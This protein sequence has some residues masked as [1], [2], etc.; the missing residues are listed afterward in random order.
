MFVKG[1]SVQKNVKGDWTN[2]LLT[3][4]ADSIFL[5][6]VEQQTTLAVRHR[7]M[8]SRDVTCF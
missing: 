5:P 7:H 1:K 3:F 6:P 8:A 2:R 4:N